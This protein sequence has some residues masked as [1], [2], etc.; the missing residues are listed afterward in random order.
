[1]IIFNQL[2]A[3]DKSFD[4]V[5]CKEKGASDILDGKKSP[6]GLEDA[7]GLD[8]E[9]DFEEYNENDEEVSIYLGAK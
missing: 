3:D 4:D 8:Y 9:D 7:P 1:M 5:S 2:C 6:S